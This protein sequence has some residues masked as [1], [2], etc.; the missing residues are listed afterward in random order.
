MAII[1]K[2]ILGGF[3]GKVG[4]VVGG[5]WRGI[6]YIRS[7]P[8]KVSRIPSLSQLE[9]RAKFGLAVGFLKK[10]KPVL[11]LGFP[12]T[13]KASETPMNEACSYFIQHSITGRFP[14]FGVDFKEV[15]LSKGSLA[16]LKQAKLIYADGVI[17]LSWEFTNGGLFG[18]G[19]DQVILIIYVVENEEVQFLNT[20]KR[21]DQ[22]VEYQVPKD[23]S[24]LE[25]VTWAFTYNKQNKQASK[26]QFLGST[27][28]F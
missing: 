14:T 6:Q 17:K 3:S 10:V 28:L 27:K 19:N 26:T 1:S 4:N 21:Q 25:V 9:Q 2:G 7:L 24:G 12:K 23:L 8:K 15:Q 22:L 16:T 5:N 13:A 20:S 18:Q 11:E